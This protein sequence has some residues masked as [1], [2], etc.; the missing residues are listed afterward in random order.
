MKLTLQIVAFIALASATMPATENWT[1]YLVDSRCYETAARNVSPWS[2]STVDRD[3]DLNIRQCR[4]NAKTKFFALVQFD[5]KAFEI[6]SAGAEKAAE[7]VRNAP[8]QKTYVVNVVGSIE[9]GLLKLDSI[10]MVTQVQPR[11]SPVHYAPAFALTILP[12]LLNF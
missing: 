2:T 7:L 10:S 4:P 9:N 11:A 12:E 6:Y 5:W 8:K 3:M 1:G